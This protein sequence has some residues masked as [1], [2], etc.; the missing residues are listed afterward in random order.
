MQSVFRTGS[1]ELGI[2][3]YGVDRWSRVATFASWSCAPQHGPGL[4]DADPMQGG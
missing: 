2:G 1:C 3:E 4:D